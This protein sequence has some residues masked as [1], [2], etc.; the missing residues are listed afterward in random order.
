M[1][2]HDIRFLR[3][4]RTC[5]TLA[6]TFTDEGSTL[7]DARYALGRDGVYDSAPAFGGVRASSCGGSRTLLVG[8]GATEGRVDEGPFE[9]R[10]DSDDVR[11]ADGERLE[12]D[13]TSRAAGD[14]LAGVRAE[15]DDAS[16]GEDAGAGVRAVAEDE[17]LADRRA[18]ADVDSRAVAGVG[19][20]AD[21]RAERDNDVRRA[22]DCLPL[23]LVLLWSAPDC[24]VGESA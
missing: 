2:R 22:E 9:T 10:C 15:V 13:V 14:V 12:L 16:P 23:M 6:G 19:S 1:D 20:P 18:V 21:S 11:T 3:I 5:S 7:V 8:V 4:D 17:S 24:V